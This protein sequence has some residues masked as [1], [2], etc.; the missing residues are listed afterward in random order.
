[1]TQPQTHP[2]DAAFSASAPL[3]GTF[4]W[5][6]LLST[7]VPASRGFYTALLGWRPEAFDMGAKGEYTYLWSGDRRFGGIVAL[8]AAHGIPSHWV[9]Y[10]G[11][12]DVD[13]AVARA[14]AAGARVY[15]PPTDAPGGIRFTTLGDPFGA[16]FSIIHLPDPATAAVGGEN[17][18][19]P[20]SAWWHEL[21]TPD[22]DGALAFYGA[23][24]GWQADRQEM[25]GDLGAYWLLK[26]GGRQ[27][28]GMYRM[29][30]DAPYPSF[31]QIYVAVAD[32]DASVARAKELGATMTFGIVDVEKTGRIAGFVDPV[33]AAFAIGEAEEM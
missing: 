23:V 28:G 10:V 21:A 4:V 30:V 14:T 26:R 13:A 9:S 20:G 16:V 18:P 8:D 27:I 3:D 6:D 11:A 5:H 33:G 29:P 24:F 32:I 17:P 12:S 15:M 2:A 1:M 25:G 7:D 22:P 19:T 31:W